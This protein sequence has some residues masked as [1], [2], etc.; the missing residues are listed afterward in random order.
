MIGTYI[1]PECFPIF[2]LVCLKAKQDSK[3]ENDCKKNQSE[4]KQSENKTPDVSVNIRV[5]LCQARMNPSLLT[6]HPK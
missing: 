5:T 4:N 6:H 3:Q 2:H 1:Q